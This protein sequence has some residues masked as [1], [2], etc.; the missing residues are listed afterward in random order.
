[1]EVLSVGVATNNCTL[2]QWYLW[3]AQ[4]EFCPSS[5]LKAYEQTRGYQYSSPATFAIQSSNIDS[6]Y[7]DGVSIIY[8]SNSRQHI[9]T[10]TGGLTETHLD[11]YSCPCNNG[12]SASP[13]P[14]VCNDYYCESAVEYVAYSSML[15]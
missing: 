4:K 14:F 3:L 5:K 12:S 10:Y 6:C 1:M 2:K 8:G 9:W 15:C 13:P 11:S 7:V